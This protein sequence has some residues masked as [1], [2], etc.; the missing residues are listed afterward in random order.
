MNFSF[1]YKWQLIYLLFKVADA[2]C[3]K[4]AADLTAV[5]TEADVRAAPLHHSIR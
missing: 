2:F 1:K 3:P 5:W 4:Y